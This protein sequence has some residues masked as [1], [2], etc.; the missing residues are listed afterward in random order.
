MYD[1]PHW[2]TGHFQPLMPLLA[3]GVYEEDENGCGVTLAFYK[4]GMKNVTN[5]VRGR[6]VNK[7]PRGLFRSRERFPGPTSARRP[8]A[9]GKG[10][11]Y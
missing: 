7:N 6:K 5:L 4:T 1:T 3:H 9:A 2:T 11:S 10:T 8:P